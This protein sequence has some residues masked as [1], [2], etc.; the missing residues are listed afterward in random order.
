MDNVRQL[1]ILDLP[2]EILHDIF[3]H[4]SHKPHYG[5]PV[6]IGFHKRFVDEEDDF[7]ALQNVRLV[8]RRF[9]G[10]A[11]PLLVPVVNAYINSES[12]SR[13]D[14]LT[15]NPLIA[16]G[17][18][19]VKLV[20]EYRPREVAQDW[21]VYKDLQLRNIHELR[22]RCKLS[23]RYDDR[24]TMSVEELKISDVLAKI[25]NESDAYHDPRDGN[26]R[27]HSDEDCLKFQ[28]LLYRCFKEYRKRHE[29]QY[30]LLKSRSLVETLVV[31]IGRM[32]SLR[33][34]SAVDHLRKPLDNHWSVSTVT[35]LANDTDEFHPSDC[36]GAY[37]NDQQPRVIV[38][39][40]C[41]RSKRPAFPQRICF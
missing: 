37:A 18:R 12:L 10:V 39:K 25:T 26:P 30:Q 1:N 13:I 2:E 38:A 3:D 24:E 40:S 27:L 8:C 17:V 14:M 35:A 32:T 7:N 21:E 31:L 6:K 22:S 20:L 34:L 19:Q 4:F 41:G 5:N 11:S 29:E 15:K 23:M 28:K 9:C 33:S 36:R 16:T